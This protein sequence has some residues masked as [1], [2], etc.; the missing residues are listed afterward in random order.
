VRTGLIP[1]A[2]SIY[3]YVVDAMPGVLVPTLLQL[4]AFLAAVDEGSFTA[5]SQ[6]LGMTQPAVSRAVA[7]L[8]REL[9]LPVLIRG[10]GGLSL[11]DAGSRALH[12]HGR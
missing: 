4:K 8:E 9:G 6:R 2:A 5:A 7:T 3:R 11:T 1:I 12:T 10:S